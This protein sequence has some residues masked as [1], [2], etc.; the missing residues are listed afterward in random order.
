MYPLF[1]EKQKPHTICGARFVHI[2]Q[3]KGTPTTKRTFWEL[4]NFKLHLELILQDK[5]TSRCA[6]VDFTLTA[7][8]IYKAI[9][10]VLVTK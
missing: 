2:W 4:Y 3:G 6:A 10:N 9:F 5:T 1:A 7:D 8:L